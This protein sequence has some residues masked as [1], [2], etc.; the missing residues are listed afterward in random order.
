MSLVHGGFLPREGLVCHFDAANTIYDQY[1]YVHYTLRFIGNDRIVVTMNGVECYN[2]I[3][4]DG[5][6][7]YTNNTL[8]FGTGMN[9]SLAMVI[10]YNRV[11]GDGEMA[12]IFNTFKRRFFR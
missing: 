10:L 6:T 9:M 4:G 11:L 1:D 5:Y 12:T 8:A 2:T 7:G 3:I